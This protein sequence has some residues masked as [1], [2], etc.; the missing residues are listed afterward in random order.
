MNMILILY[1][2]FCFVAPK[3]FS[4]NLGS[5]AYAINV[6]DSE[7]D[8]ASEAEILWEGNQ[9]MQD[10]YVK[11]VQ[12]QALKRAQASLSNQI[13]RSLKQTAPSYVNTNLQ[14]STSVSIDPKPQ[15]AA[16]T[17]SESDVELYAAYQEYLKAKGG[18][19]PNVSAANGPLYQHLQDFFH[20][21]SPAPTPVIIV[22]VTQL[23]P[24]PQAVPRQQVGP[25][26]R[27]QQGSGGGPTIVGSGGIHI[28]TSNPIAISNP[29]NIQNP[30]INAQATKT[31]GKG[32]RILNLI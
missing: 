8:P 16:K 13:G 12:Q 21:E 19:S 6:S 4:S 18:S 20:K 28:V 25:Q 32:R 15:Q 3:A 9:I 29:I 11:S 22:P 1:A 10:A 2:M 5:T 23:A 27:P 26:A 30:N 7:Y 31:F 17:L 24:Q 14:K